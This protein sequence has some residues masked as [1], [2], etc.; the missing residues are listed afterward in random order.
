MEDFNNLRQ[1]LYEEEG[2]EEKIIKRKV[3]KYLRENRDNYKHKH[4]KRLYQFY[5][6]FYNIKSLIFSKDTF[7]Y[8]EKDLSIDDFYNF[9]L[10]IIDCTKADIITFID[11]MQDDNFNNE[12]IIRINFDDRRRFNAYLK[13]KHFCD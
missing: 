13:F 11:L 1:E 6:I 5:T 2:I 8:T 12:E 3:S 10:Y 7:D 4:I 9:L